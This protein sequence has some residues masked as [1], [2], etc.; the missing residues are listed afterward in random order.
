MSLTRRPEYL[1]STFAIT[2]PLDEHEAALLERIQPKLSQAETASNIAQ[3]LSELLLSLM[4]LQN[5]PLFLPLDVQ[6]MLYTS[7]SVDEIFSKI[8]THLTQEYVRRMPDKNTSEISDLVSSATESLSLTEAIRSLNTWSYQLPTTPEEQV[9]LAIETN[10]KLQQANLE[11]T[12]QR[13]AEEQLNRAALYLALLQELPSPFILQ[14]FTA[15]PQPETD[16]A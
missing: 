10:Q 14:Q 1:D 3:Q 12:D 13:L 6:S 8:Q 4:D 5:C 2:L 9:R 7:Y 11:K 16:T 15:A